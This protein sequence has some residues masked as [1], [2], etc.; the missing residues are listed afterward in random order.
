MSA[1]HTKSSRSSKTTE[2]RPI[3]EVRRGRIKAAIWENETTSGTR[4]NVTFIRIYRDGEEW[5]S[6]D[7]FGRDDLPLVMKVAD[8][9]HTWIYQQ[10]QESAKAEKSNS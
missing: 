4:H 10:F 3:H 7:S 2:N 9:A 5:K 6:S 8:L 1:T